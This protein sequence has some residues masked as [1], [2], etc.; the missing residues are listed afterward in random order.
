MRDKYFDKPTIYVSHPIRGVSG[1]M[2]GNC[3]K[4]QVGI[5][6]LR[7]LF[8]EVDW[9]L[10]ADGDL[11]I[12]I[13]YDVGEL[14]EK[15]ILDADLEILRAC[16][17]WFYYRFEESGGSEIERKGAIQ[18]NLVDGEEHDVRYDLSKASY[19]AIRKTF[20]PIVAKAVKRFRE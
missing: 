6:K 20:N 2:K 7:H 10:P 11:I 19:P 18:A 14:S 4:A 8:P 5:R 13:L 12:Q 17:G 15:A 9:H 1:D 3:H 16:S